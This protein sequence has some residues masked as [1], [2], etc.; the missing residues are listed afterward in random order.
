M[1]PLACAASRARA[2]WSTMLRA[3][4]TSR[5]PWL[6]SR[7]PRSSPFTY[8]MAMYRS[9][10]GIS[11]AS[12]TG[13]MLGWSSGGHLR[14]LGEPLARP[15]VLEQV[16]S[17]DLE[18]HL[19]PHAGVLGEVDHAH[20]ALGDL[21]LDLVAADHR[22]DTRVGGGV[23]GRVG[24]RG[25]AGRLSGERRRRVAELDLLPAPQRDGTGQAVAVH[26][27]AVRRPQVLQPDAAVWGRVQLGMAP[28]DLVVHKDDVIGAVPSDD[29]RL[30]DLERGGLAIELPDREP[31]GLPSH[32]SLC[33]GADCRR[34]VWVSPWGFRPIAR[35]PGSAGPPR[36]PG[37]ERFG[38]PTC[39]AWSGG[40]S[41][42]RSAPWTRRVRGP[43]RK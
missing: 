6:S 39:S 24:R 8:F 29:D 21:G 16:G 32:L 38:G 11:S 7:R 40:P 9:P 19:A 31:H 10:P 22:P 30:R 27:R 35:R 34:R 41:G 23:A 20:G 1:R 18:G 13:M 37:A 43:A 2:T 3:R 26:E 17:E 5:G 4:F 36:V 14:L 15:R 42:P 33:L 28:G 12:Y 25:R